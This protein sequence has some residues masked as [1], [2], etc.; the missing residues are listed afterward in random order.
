MNNENNFQASRPSDEQPLI[1]LVQSPDV[2]ISG[3]YALEKQGD[4]VHRFYYMELFLLQSQS[5][6][7]LDAQGRKL[8]LKET[9]KKFDEKNRAAICLEG[10]AL[11][12]IWGLAKTLYVENKLQ[13][14]ISNPSDIE[15]SLKSGILI[16]FDV[17]SILQQAKTY[18]D[19]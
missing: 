2:N 12:R 14:N 8:L 19:E 18:S 6:Q 9:L 4:F 5:L 10:I 16:D 1:R 3:F 17:S 11:L 7:S 15:S 13:T